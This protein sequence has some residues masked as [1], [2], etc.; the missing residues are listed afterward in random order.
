MTVYQ[1][2]DATIDVLTVSGGAI[3][4]FSVAGT[5]LWPQGSL[6][7]ETVVSPLT[8]AFV[9]VNGSPVDTTFSGVCD[10][11]DMYITPINVVL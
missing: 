10:S 3:L 9:Q 7:S 5:E 11:G 1:V 2:A 8:S 6:G 4:T